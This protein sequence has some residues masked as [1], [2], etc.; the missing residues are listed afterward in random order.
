MI[1][2]ISGEFHERLSKYPLVLVDVGASGGLMA[3]FMILKKYLK[4]VG[5]EPDD[6]AYSALTGLNTDQTIILNRAL[7]NKNASIEFYTNKNP[8]TSSLLKPNK[9]FLSLFPN[10]GD[11]DPVKTDRLNA[12][13]LDEALISNGIHDVDFIKL[14]TQG[15]ELFILE[16]GLR[17]LSTCFGLEIEVEFCPVYQGQPLFCDVDHF[18]RKQGFVLFDLRPV[19]WKRA[20]GLEYGK[21]KGQLVWADGLYFKDSKPFHESFQTLDDSRKFQRTLNAVLISVL[22]GYLDYALELTDRLKG[23]VQDQEIKGRIEVLERALKK[24]YFANFLPRSPILRNVIA[25]LFHYPYKT[26]RTGF[27]EH[28]I[29]ERDLGNL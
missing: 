5:F 19:Y 23:T 17:T 8:V 25:E 22:Y 18:L 11:Y 9:E 24:K 28:S 16:G 29:F 27:E 7:Y 10:P 26:F 2:K 21:P 14:D 12:T 20:V 15:S 3:N 6:A 1:R 13:P 4:T